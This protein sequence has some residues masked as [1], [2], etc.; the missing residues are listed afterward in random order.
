[1]LK[2]T[3]QCSDGPSRP[4][5]SAR[6]AAGA[7]EESHRLIFDAATGFTNLRRL[8][9]L[10]HLAQGKTADALILSRELGMSPTAATRHIA[11]LVRRGYLCVSRSGHRVVCQ[12]AAKAK[13]PAH[14]RLL[15][16]VA[17]FWDKGACR[18]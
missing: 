16:I 14:A 17:A 18:S 12:L 15:D 13:T 10:R 7:Q 4:P 3:G 11:K 5:E 8:Q 1:L 2:A 6:A 9:V